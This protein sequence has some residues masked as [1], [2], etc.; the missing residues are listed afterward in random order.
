MFEY[1]YVGNRG[2]SPRSCRFR[3]VLLDTLL[4]RTVLVPALAFSL[5]DRFWWPGRIAPAAE[6]SPAGEREAVPIA[7]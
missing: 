6:G 7:G 2:A 4:V 3:A 1:Y 5:G